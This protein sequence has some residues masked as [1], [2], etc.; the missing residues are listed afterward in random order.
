VLTYTKRQLKS[1]QLTFVRINTAA[2][3]PCQTTEPE[4]FI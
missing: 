3:L 1:Q 2:V 4:R